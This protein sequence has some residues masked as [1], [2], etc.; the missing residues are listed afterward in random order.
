MIKELAQ[1][2]VFDTPIPAPS[3]IPQWT[4]PF[5]PQQPGINPLARTI[6]ATGIQVLFVFAILFALYQLIKS[7]IAWIMSE[8]DKQKLQDARNGVIFSI[9]G[10]LIIFTSFFVIFLFSHFFNV[11]L[12]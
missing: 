4:A 3:S 1:L 2:R 7:G 8:G 12:L 6:I 9:V 11:P 5:G 10:L